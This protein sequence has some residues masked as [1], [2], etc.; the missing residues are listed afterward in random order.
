MTHTNWLTVDKDGLAQTL[1]GRSKAF[2]IFEAVQNALDEPG[3]T[4]IDITLE[5]IP[6]SPY[7]RMVVSDDAPEGWADLTHAYTMFAPSKKKGDAELRGR[8]NV[9]EK[10]ILALA[11]RASITTTKGRVVFDEEGRRFNK[12]FKYDRGS[13]LEVEVRMTN[14][15]M[16]EALRMADLIIVPSHITLTVNGLACE[17]DPML[18]EVEATLPTIVSDA[19]G[20]L[21]KS[22]RKTKVRVYEPFVATEHDTD[23]SAWLYEMG[24]PVVPI[25]CEWSIDVQQRVP[26]NVDRDN[27]PPAYL[28]KLLALVVNLM[29]SKIEDASASWVQEAVEHKDIEPAALA[30]VLDKRYGTKRV[31]FD[32]SDIEAN[33][34][35]QAEGYTVV[36]G[37]S[38]GSGI[39]ANVRRFR[40]T[41]LDLI[42]PAGQVTPSTRGTWEARSAANPDA[43]TMSP[44]D[45]DDMTPAWRDAIAFL[46]RVGHAMLGRSFPVNLYPRYPMGVRMAASWSQSGMGLDRLDLYKPAWSAPEIQS[47]KALVDI[48]IHELAH[49]VESDHLSERYYKALSDFGAVATMLALEKPRLFRL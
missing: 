7:V 21:R 9:G 34:R 8:F 49:S 33:K 1:E 25:D 13:T 16:E 32:P 10:W 22:N 11:R 19:D 42:R 29:S 14:D 2:V 12:S 43:P 3:V 40:E 39:G 37:R 31:M 5:R 24:I 35:A 4:R 18:Y 47:R 36:Y 45:E 46:K 41:G 48:L 27:V 6:N 26:L 38:L 28:A 23:P 20:V 15:E 44:I 17:T 30:N